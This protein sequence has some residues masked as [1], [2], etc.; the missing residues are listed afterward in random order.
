MSPD[1]K[2]L[3][4]HKIHYF[5]VCSFFDGTPKKDQYSYYIIIITTNIIL[6]NVMPI[7]RIIGVTK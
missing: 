5:R 2:D 7:I 6:I 3:I 4:F 1:I